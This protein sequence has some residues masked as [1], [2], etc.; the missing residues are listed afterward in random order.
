[1]IRSKTFD[2][3]GS[4]LT[5]RIIRA[6]VWDILPNI[7]KNIDAL[8]KFKK[9]IKIGNLGIVLVEFVRSILQVW[10]LYRIKRVNQLLTKY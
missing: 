10:F 2:T 7:Y 9:S 4:G 8:D 5:G 6:K 3:C 1:M